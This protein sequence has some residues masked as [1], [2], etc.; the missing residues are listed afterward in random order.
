MVVIAKYAFGNFFNNERITTVRLAKF[1]HD[2]QNRL[3]SQNTNDEYTPIITI[4]KDPLQGVQDE[5]DQV[6]VALGIQKGKTLT[7]DQFIKLFKKTMREKEGVIADAVGG[8]DSAGY[9]EFYPKGKTEYSQATKTE[10]PK[11]VDRVSILAE[12]HAGQLSPALVATLQAFKTSWN[13]S[14]DGQ[15]QQKGNLSDN[16][17]DRN[18]LRIKLEISLLVAIHQIALK[19]PGNEEQCKKFFDFNL[20]FAVPKGKK[21]D[22]TQN[23]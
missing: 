9:L 7:V 15:E 19:F 2:A 17:V 1:G 12:S 18:E 3:I 13:L 20:L 6:D 22:D 21:K 11:L 14:R 4:F 8:F 5:I 16:R 10:M 23:P